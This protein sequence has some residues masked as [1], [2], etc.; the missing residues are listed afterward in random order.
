MRKRGPAS[1]GS[2]LSPPPQTWLNRYRREADVKQD[3]LARVTGMS[4]RTLSRLENGEVK[5]PPLRYLVNRAYALGLDDWQL[6]L[7]DEWQ[8]WLPLRGRTPERARTSPFVR[9]R[10]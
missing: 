7:E 9:P 8:E 1:D 3:E 6:L 5:N 4:E 2:D 10:S